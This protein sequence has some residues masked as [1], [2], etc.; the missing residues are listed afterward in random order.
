M[1][2]LRKGSL[3]SSEHFPRC[4]ILHSGMRRDGALR[5]VEHATAG[6]PCSNQ[7]HHQRAALEGNICLLRNARS[8]LEGHVHIADERDKLPLLDLVPA[9]LEIRAQAEAAGSSFLHQVPVLVLGSRRRR[10]RAGEALLHARHAAGHEGHAGG[11]Q[12]HEE[13]VCDEA[14]ELLGLLARALRA[15]QHADQHPAPVGGA[16]TSCRPARRPAPRSRRRRRP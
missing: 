8:T 1:R 7:R 5:K 9:S 16:S 11:R 4:R 3:L 13:G 6:A 10:A 12:G 2:R 14:D 15:A